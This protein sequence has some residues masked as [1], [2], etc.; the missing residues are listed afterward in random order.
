MGPFPVFLQYNRQSLKKHPLN[1]KLLLVLS[2]PHRPRSRGIG[3]TG[4][5]LAQYFCFRVFP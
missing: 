4:F 2:F 3:F 1:L 5:E